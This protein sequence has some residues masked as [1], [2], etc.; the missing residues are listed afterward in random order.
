MP[1]NAKDQH[2]QT[3]LHFGVKYGNAEVVQK[4]LSFS[5]KNRDISQQ[6]NQT[7]SFPIEIEAQNMYG[8]TPLFYVLYQLGKCHG[9]KEHIDDMMGLPFY[10]QKENW[11]AMKLLLIK[12]GTSF[13]L[14]YFFIFDCKV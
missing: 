12:S 14:S 3:A 2:S 4:L 8:Q 10:K 5:N 6:S 7:N 9:F 1:I 11:E 13:S